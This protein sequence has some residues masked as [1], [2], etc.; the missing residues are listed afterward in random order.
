[1]IVFST[2]LFTIC[3]LFFEIHPIN[4]LQSMKK[5]FL[6]LTYPQRKRVVNEVFYYSGVIRR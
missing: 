6:M 1:M 2:Y 5:T 4:L 3:Y